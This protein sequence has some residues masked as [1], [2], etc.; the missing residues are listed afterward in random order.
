MKNI[1]KLSF[2]LLSAM[3]LA[4]MIAAG[5]N[6]WLKPMNLF[7]NTQTERLIGGSM[8][9]IIFVCLFKVFVSN[10]EKKSIDVVSLKR[11]I[12]IVKMLQCFV[13]MTGIIYILNYLSDCLTKIIKLIIAVPAENITY[14]ETIGKD[15][16]MS[17]QFICIVIISPIAEEII[18]RKI[19]LERLLPY[20]TATAIFGSSLFFGMSHGN[21]EQFL[22]TLFSGIIFANLVIISGKLYYSIFMHMMINFW[23]GIVVEI[24]QEQQ[25]IIIGMMVF[26][27]LSGILIL[28]FNR[29]T[30]FIRYLKENV[31]KFSNKKEFVSTG[32]VIYIAFF[33]ISCIG[34]IYG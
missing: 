19:L 20:G 11:P 34:I 21:I 7:L 4:G 28:F 15:L 27:I 16:P 29:K 2:A 18:F 31:S 26:F 13:A 5:L 33:V 8:S 12:S 25:N 14:V 9:N 30:M 32:F 24:I 10:I 6:E 23:G 1:S 17:I 22:Y 3:L